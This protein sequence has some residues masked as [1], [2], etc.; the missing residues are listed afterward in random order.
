[1]V[2]SKVCNGCKIDKL[3][4]EY[5]LRGDGG[6]KYKC[7][8]C[9]K[10]DWH[11][12]KTPELLKRRSVY[13][14]NRYNDLRKRV[15]ANYGGKCVC[16]MESTLPFLALDHINAGG[17]KHKQTVGFGSTFYKWVE[18]NGYPDIL[19]VL[20]HNCNQAKRDNAF[21]PHQYKEV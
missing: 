18:D 12:R 4:S 9:L 14:K 19:Q 3:P 2:K 8:E 15:I 20:C 1:M 5:H 13:A 6:L 21:C 16:C 11:K 10:I 7:K 17:R